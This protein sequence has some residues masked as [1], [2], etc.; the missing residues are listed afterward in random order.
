MSNSNVVVLPVTRAAARADAATPEQPAEEARISRYGYRVGPMTLLVAPG[1]V[2]EISVLPEIT[3]LPRS[4]R[5]LAGCTNIRGNIVPV[6]CLH[7]LIDAV[8][9]RAD[10]PTVLLLDRGTRMLGLLIDGLPQALL[11]TATASEL[12]PPNDALSGFIRS[13]FVVNG[14]LWLEFDAHGFFTQLAANST[15][16]RSAAQR[17]TRSE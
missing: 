17:K 13:G 7:P 16:S 10:R 9:V 15:S 14:N 11:Q 12:L 2:S 1:M 6:F 5:W 8:R 4:V 3:P